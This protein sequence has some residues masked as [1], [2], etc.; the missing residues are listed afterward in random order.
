MAN[1]SL[2]PPM[3]KSGFQE[4][5]RTKPEGVRQFVK[6][7]IVGGT[8]TVLD[9]ASNYVLWHFFRFI[10]Y[11]MAD[12]CLSV[13]TPLAIAPDEQK[14]AA[15][16]TSVISSGI[17]GTANAFYWNRRWTFRATE[18]GTAG[19]QMKK[20]F[21]VAY[22]G[23]ALRVGAAQGGPERPR[24]AAIQSDSD[25]YRHVLEFLYEPILDV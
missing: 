9:L 6:F 10:P 19:S 5:I 2:S 11:A 15:A 23:M 20:F 12:W 18:P 8:S 14:L 4:W 1:G 21:V 7:A 13:L 3:E 16:M 25:F 24:D 22:S 17:I